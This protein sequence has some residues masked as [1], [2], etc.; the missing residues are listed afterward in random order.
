MV[1]G[2]CRGGMYSD[3]DNSGDLAQQGNHR[4]I[5][6][7]E[8]RAQKKI[9]GALFL[10]VI[11]LAV[12]CYGYY[13]YSRQMTMIEESALKGRR[14][15]RFFM[16]A[17]LFLFWEPVCFLSGC[18]RGW[19]RAFT[20]LGRDGGSRRNMQRSLRLSK[21]GAGSILLCCFNFNGLT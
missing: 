2:G 19:C 17:L 3:Y 4:K 5:K 8:K 11:F 20:R 1:C 18:F 13:N 12:G 9:M 6:T 15:I 21:T 10:D 16:S 14:W 7:A